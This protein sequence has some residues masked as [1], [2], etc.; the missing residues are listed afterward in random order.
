[1]VNLQEPGSLIIGYDFSKDVNTGVLVV[2]RQRTGG[3]VVDVINAF[4]GPEALKLLNQLTTKP[5]KVNADN[6]KA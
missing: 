1:M 6:V 2:G 5:K 3:K 4:E